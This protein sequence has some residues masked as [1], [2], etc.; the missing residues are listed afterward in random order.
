MQLRNKEPYHKLLKKAIKGDQ[1]ALRA[2]YDLLFD[3]VVATISTFHL[4]IEESEDLVQEAFIKIFRQLPRYDYR[5]STLNTWSALIA[6]G[7]AIKYVGKNR[8]DTTDLAMAKVLSIVPSQ[9]NDHLEYS[10]IKYHID[11]L[12]ANYREVFILSVLEDLDH[13]TI[14]RRMDISISTS[15]VYLSRAKVQLQKELAHLRTP[16][17]TIKS[18]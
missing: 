10:I 9:D 16:P 4:S 13:A 15:R 8:L 5:K 17:L 11:K 18:V 1:T 3:N 12:P 6:R 14:S 7:L 2:V